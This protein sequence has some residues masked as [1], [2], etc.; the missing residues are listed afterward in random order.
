MFIK[1]LTEITHEIQ[2]TESAAVPNMQ[3]LQVRY[4]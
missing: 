4:D 3:I 2:R 1:D